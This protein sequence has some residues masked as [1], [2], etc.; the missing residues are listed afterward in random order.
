MYSNSL[1]SEINPQ[2]LALI[3]ANNDDQNNL[4]LID[5]RELEEV[6]IANIPQFMI[7]LPLSQFHQW[8]SKIKTELDQNKETIVMCHHGIRS[9]QMCQ[10]LVNQGFTKVKNLTGGID[11]YALTVDS[12]IPRY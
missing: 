7:I 10:W 4:Q 6:A 11:Y 8:S 3:L 5:V 12:N 2:E 1:F 9:G